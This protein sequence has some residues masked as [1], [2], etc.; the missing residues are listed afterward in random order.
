MLHNL[1][2]IL[3]RNIVEYT[4]NQCNHCSAHLLGLFLAAVPPTPQNVAIHSPS[5]AS[6][7]V[8]WSPLTPVSAEYGTILQYTISCSAQDVTED[9]HIETA[10]GNATQFDVT[11]LEPSTTY[12]CCVSAENIAGKGMAVCGEGTTLQDSK[13]YNTNTTPVL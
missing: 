5:S 4:S 11:A 3:L 10:Q 7:R 1:L 6:L 13:G 8:Q 12:N 2:C 9:K